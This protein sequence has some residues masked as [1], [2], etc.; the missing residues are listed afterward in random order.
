MDRQRLI[1]LS[2]LAGLIL[3]WTAWQIYAGWGLVTLDER[4]AP[5]GKVLPANRSA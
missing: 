4:E 2:L 3:V 1:S 5:V